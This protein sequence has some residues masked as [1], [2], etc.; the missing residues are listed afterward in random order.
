MPNTVPMLVGILAVQGNFAE[1]ESIVRLLGVPVVQVRTLGD[2]AACTHLII[3]G[4]ESTVMAKHLAISG[5]D[6]MIPKRVTEKSLSVLGTCAGAIL[7]A[8]NVIGRNAPVTLNVLDI[9]V[10]RNAYGAQVHS[11]EAKV[12]IQGIKAPVLA[13]FIRAPVITKTGGTVRVLAEHEGHPVAVRSANV[14]AL[15]FHPELHGET[16]VHQLFLQADA[17]G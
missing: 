9:D 10:D 16:A 6:T 7:L 12:S 14:W 4:G 8:K 3:P 11:F 2:L 1:H 17:E 15:T 13:S 5:L